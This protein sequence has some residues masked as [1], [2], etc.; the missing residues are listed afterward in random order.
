SDNTVQSVKMEYPQVKLIA[1]KN[2]NGFAKGNNIAAE[3]ATG[4]YLL[5]LNP[6]T[7]VLDGAI[8]K[9]LKFAR[10]NPDS[11][12][13]G[14]RT[15]FPDGSLNRSCY[16]KMTLWSLICSII[17]FTKIFSF[18]TFF[19]PIPYG[20]WKY[21]TTRYVDIISGCFLMIKKEIWEKLEGFNPLFFMYA[22]EVDLC[23]RAKKIG[24]TPQFYPKAEIVHY[25]GA[26]ETNRA[27]KIIKIYKGELT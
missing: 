16:S 1:S 3:T 22:E 2:N 26:S 23:L 9:L 14:G 15:I 8:E 5:L 10:R 20:S 25:R 24:Y 18:S 11:G 6:D 12:I 19:N 7:I 4:E 13:Y 21:N 17:G 27:D